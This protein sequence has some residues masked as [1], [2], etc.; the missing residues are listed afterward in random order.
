MV[1]S[2]ISNA[3]DNLARAG[4]SSGFG[5]FGERAGF[6]IG[7]AFIPYTNDNTYLRAFFVGLLN[8][9]VVAIIGIFSRPSSALSSVWRGCRRT[10]WCRNLRRSMWKCCATF[11]CC[12]SCCSGTRRFCRSC[13]R[14][15]KAPLRPGVEIAFSINNR[16]LYLPRLVPED[17]ASLIFY[18]FRCRR[19]AWFLIGRW[20]KKRQ[21][22]TGQQFPVFLY[23]TGQW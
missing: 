23:R 17:G 19:V 7:Q 6:D 8:T 13:R 10:T 12:C 9:M 1:W 18:A 14:R 20:A 4:I 5:F 16:G 22:E 21:M 2:G 3:I 11:R 15:A